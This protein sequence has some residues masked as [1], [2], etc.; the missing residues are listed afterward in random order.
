MDRSSF[1]SQLRRE[2]HER[3]DHLPVRGTGP[4][5]VRRTATRRR[6]RHQLTGVTVTVTLV[7]AATASVIATRDPGEQ[8]LVNA[9][10]G[11]V[12]DV[13]PASAPPFDW[14]V[15]DEHSAVGDGPAVVTGA[16]GTLYVLSTAP[17]AQAPTDDGTYTPPPQALYASADGTHW[18][19]HAVADLWIGSLAEQDG[20][21]YA[22]G[23][24]PSTAAVGGIDAVT[25]RSTDGGATW[26][27]A[28][29]PLT[30]GTDPS[31]L[32]T[33]LGSSVAAT[34]P[35]GV[36]AATTTWSDLDVA[37]LF[38]AGALDD[39]YRTTADGVDVY[40]PITDP[41]LIAS[42]AC[43]PGW[44]AT[45]VPASDAGSRGVDA[46]GAPAAAVP[47]PVAV[48]DRQLAA[49]LKPSAG[50]Q[51]ASCASPDAGVEPLLVPVPSQVVAHH[52][53]AE[54]QVDPAVGA[55]VGRSAVHVF[56]AADGHTFAEVAVP[57]ATANDVHLL[58][59]ADGYVALTQASSGGPEDAE[60]AQT[61]TAWRSTDG[62][63]WSPIAAPAL[64]DV[65][66]VAGAGVVDGAL[67][68]V[69]SGGRFLRST[70]GGTWTATDLTAALGGG[71]PAG[72][73]VQVDVA[74][75]GAAGIV[76]SADVVTPPTLQ[77]ITHD[78]VTLTIDGD[79][80]QITDAATG[81][82][83]A[84]AVPAY[85]PSATSAVRVDPAGGDIVVL[86]P[87]TG[88]VRARFGYEEIKRALVEQP[89]DP[90]AAVLL[91]STDG[92][93]VG[94]TRISDLIGGAT[95]FVS[96]I[97]VTDRALVNI[98]RSGEGT[99]AGARVLLVGAPPR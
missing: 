16:D 2:L 10:A 51:V 73:K 31:G 95:G 56:V 28:P 63:T 66:S 11:A 39:G 97:D 58:A 98:S 32:R 19:Q 81:A 40:G 49:G 14:R 13:A 92:V 27:Q 17:G 82:V 79:T 43:P 74:G 71:V 15:L 62:R 94:T 84:D 88:A 6:R 24:A 46:N 48:L 68:V 21:L 59:T 45:L 41:A 75:V 50:G 83:L 33:Y 9:G 29:L 72:A 42:K 38:P 54:L 53:W 96:W 4:A 12:A 65:A 87:A 26:T 7:G 85:S 23:T 93:H 91:T 30:L 37:G 22:V 57:F 8:A 44:T 1:E 78:G 76:A 34:G 3:G 47:V 55:Q 86:D 36:V 69:D 35:G 20:V 25:A 90:G 5:A 61:I 60:A 18:T 64:T 70:D 77:P 52:A 89:W 67:V 99:G 80:L